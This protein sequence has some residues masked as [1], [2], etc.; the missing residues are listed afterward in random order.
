MRFRDRVGFFQML[1]Y[2]LE[3][4]SWLML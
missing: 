4:K 2:Y 3:A 1:G